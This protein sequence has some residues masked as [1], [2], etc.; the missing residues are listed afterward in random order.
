[1]RRDNILTQKI[2]I[3]ISTVFVLVFGIQ[4]TSMLLRFVQMDDPVTD[5]L[6]SAFFHACD[7]ECIAP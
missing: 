6:S 1:M 2:H 7:E 3:V 5:S 4:V